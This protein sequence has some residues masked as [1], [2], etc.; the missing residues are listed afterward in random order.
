MRQQ[1]REYSML[2]RAVRSL[3]LAVALCASWPSAVRPQA[4]IAPSTSS[5][6]EKIHI[7]AVGPIAI[8]VED[9]DRS[10]DFYTRVLTFESISDAEVP[11]DDAAQRYHVFAP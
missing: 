9:M 1:R 5:A 3:T 10:V 11:G 8:T 6:V 4:N 7:R 2:F